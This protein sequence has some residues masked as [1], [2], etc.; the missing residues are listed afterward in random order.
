MPTFSFP[1]PIEDVE[2]PILLDEDWYNCRI[3]K[4]PEIK[5][6]KAMREDPQS[7]N[8]GKNLEIA[9]K[10]TGNAAEGSEGRMFI[11][12]VPWPSEKD[13]GKY[14]IRGMKLVDAKMQRIAEITEGFGGVIDGTDFILEENMEGFI[15]VNRQVS[16]ETGELINGV[17]LFSGVK[18]VA[19]METETGVEEESFMEPSEEEPSEEEP[20]F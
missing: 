6:N 12:Y 1:K 14:D 5:A 7:E 17:H 20:A 3:Y 19:E 10:L 9:V 4:K 2:E 13:E 15:F 18:S 11:L 8:A 16:I